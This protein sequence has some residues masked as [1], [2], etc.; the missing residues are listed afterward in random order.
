MILLPALQAAARSHASCIRNQVSSVLPNALVSRIAISG[1]MP[2]LPLT[3][4]LSACRVTPRTFAQQLRTAQRFKAIVPEYAT[5]M[6]RV[7]HGHGNCGVLTES[8]TVRIRSTLSNGSGR[9]PL[10]SRCSWSRFSHQP[11]LAGSAT[12]IG[13]AALSGAFGESTAQK[14]FAGRELGDAGAETAF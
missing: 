8:R 6:H 14:P 11:R 5:G 10:R 4:L 1:L 13:F 2:D 9:M 7:F 12:A 3:I